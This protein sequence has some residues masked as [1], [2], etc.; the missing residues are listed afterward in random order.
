MLHC[1][2]RV[3]FGQRFNLATWAGILLYLPSVEVGK[4]RKRIAATPEKKTQTQTSRTRLYGHIRPI[5]SRVT[6]SLLSKTWTHLLFSQTLLSFKKTNSRSGKSA[7][8]SH[9][10]LCWTE[11]IVNTSAVTS[12]LASLPNPPPWCVHGAQSSTTAAAQFQFHL[13]FSC[14]SFRTPFVLDL[15]LSV[16]LIRPWISCRL[17]DS[18]YPWHVSLVQLTA[19]SRLEMCNYFTAWAQRW[20]FE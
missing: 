9:L 10:I 11:H 16:F 20:R 8:D 18:L 3:L 19:L 2:Q 17:R 12:Q 15:R 1:R 7:A 14:Q 6:S 13:S 5:V 4:L